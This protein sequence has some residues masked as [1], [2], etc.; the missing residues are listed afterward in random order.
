MVEEY[1]RR[2]ARVLAE[3]PPG[4]NEP[5]LRHRVQPLLQEF[6]ATVGLTAGERDEYVVAEGK[7]ADAVFGQLVVEFKK[8]GLLSSSRALASACDQLSEYLQK[9]A[10]REGHRRLGGVIFD[11]QKLVFMRLRDG[12]V[13][14]ESPQPAEEPALADL[15]WWISSLTGTA[16]TA[17]N[18]VRDFGLEHPR[19]RA[20]IAAFYSSLTKA[21]LTDP[22]GMVAKLFQQWRI[23]FSEAIDY[24]EAFGGRKLEPLKK[25]VAKAGLEIQTPEEAERFFF[26][27]HTYFA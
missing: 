16:L 27:L 18:L 22:E 3:L 21:V 2:L 10:A 1:A 17:E 6:A 23:F 25:W 5:E 14:A 26:A 13:H 11:G 9:L 7:R 20:A 12:R 8:P 24:Q 15:L 19:S 4:C